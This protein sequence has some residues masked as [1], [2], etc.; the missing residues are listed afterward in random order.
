MRYVLTIWYVNE[1]DI[2]RTTTR[3]NGYVLTIWYVNP[4]NIVVK[5]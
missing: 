3:I 4:F 5:L 1:S 2:K